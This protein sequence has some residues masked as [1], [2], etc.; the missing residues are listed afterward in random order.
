MT[1]TTDLP[2]A[3]GW[4]W[5]RPW[6]TADERWVFQ[7]IDGL[8]VAGSRFVGLPAVAKVSQGHPECQWAGPIPEPTEKS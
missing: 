5:W 7:I 2:K 1:W 4:Y 3:P 8:R 6:P